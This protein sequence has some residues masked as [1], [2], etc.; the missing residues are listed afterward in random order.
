M[1][2][3]ISF[4]LIFIILTIFSIYGKSALL[5]SEA[6]HAFFDALVVT[7][8]IYAIKK[9]DN[10]NSVYTYGMHRME[11]LF[12]LLNILIVIIG[13]IIG[14][15]ISILFII[16]RIED[17]PFIVIIASSIAT[18]FGLIASSEEEK[19]EIK[20]SVKLHAILDT[21]SYILGII[22]GLAI[23]FTKYYILDP[24]SSLGILGI[25]VLK[26]SSQI[27]SYIDV[28][29]EKSP[30]DTYNIE[31]LLTPIFPTVHHIHVWSICP[32]IKVATLHITE[33]PNTTLLE[34]DKKRKYIEKLLSENF[35]IN[36]VTVQFETKKTD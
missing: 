31:K 5:A 30:I 6:F 9:L 13:A 23:F 35:N 16:L 27:K 32:H 3:V 14:I 20:K 36:H 19:D 18:I 25:I 8:S 4:W 22:A 12:S 1:R 11:I 2:S 34:M 7:I 33:D 29:M 15:I 28:L 21:L 17:N 10:I 24:I 26:N